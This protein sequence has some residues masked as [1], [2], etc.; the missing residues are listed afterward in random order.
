M[1]ARLPSINQFL[2][3]LAHFLK[4]LHE[5]ALLEIVDTISATKQHRNA[6]KK[7]K[8]PVPSPAKA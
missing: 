3:A 7:N 5:N 1:V 6:T 4:C 2:V 8:C